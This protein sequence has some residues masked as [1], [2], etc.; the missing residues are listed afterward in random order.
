MILEKRIE[1]GML[2]IRYKPAI[3]DEVDLFASTFYFFMVCFC[4]TFIFIV[5][6]NKSIPSVVISLIILIPLLFAL[7][8]IWLFLR[9]W[10]IIQ[11]EIKITSEELKYTSEEENL[12]THYPLDLVDFSEIDYIDA[13]SGKT[14]FDIRI[15]LGMARK[16]NLIGIPPKTIDTIIQFLLKRKIK[17]I[18]KGIVQKMSKLR[19]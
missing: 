1:K 15:K 6:F 16:I 11:R 8:F 14:R 12:M 4:L 13:Y 10:P 18:K 19:E 9:E 17:V 5:V 3:Y 2:Y 7:L